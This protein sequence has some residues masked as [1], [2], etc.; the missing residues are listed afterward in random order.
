M[1]NSITP[2]N[3]LYTLIFGIYILK[4]TASMNILVMCPADVCNPDYPK[5]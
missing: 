5:L 2:V 1:V 3:G 4:G